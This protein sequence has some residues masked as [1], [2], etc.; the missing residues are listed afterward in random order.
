MSSS[1]SLT[2][3]QLKNINKIESQLD[4]TISTGLDLLSSISEDIEN[5]KSEAFM[6]KKVDLFE[7]WVNQLLE[8]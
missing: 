4:K 8:Q 2:D 3:E 1:Y 6:N 5:H 7:K